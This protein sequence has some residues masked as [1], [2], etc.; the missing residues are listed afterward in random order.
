MSYCV[1]RHTCPNG[2]VYIG[3]TGQNPIKRWSNGG[4]YRGNC[5]FYNAILKYGWDNI[6][7]EILFSNLTK[8]EACQKEI[9]LIACHKSNDPEFGYNHSLGG[10]VNVGWHHS[11]EAKL[12]MRRPKSEEAKR[13]LSKAKKLQGQPKHWNRHG[14]E[15]WNKGKTLHYEN[16]FTCNRKKVINLDT[17]EIFDSVKDASIAYNASKIPQVCMGKRNK[18]GGCRW[19]YFEEVMPDESEH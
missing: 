12:K 18:S 14:K 9:E 7:H 4:H 1:Y 11:E 8:E 6:A 19:A 10:E 2:K 16:N 17:G 13:N 5:H 15:P 3:I